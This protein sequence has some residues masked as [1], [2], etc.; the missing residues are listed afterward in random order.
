MKIDRAQPHDV[1]TILP[2]YLG[3]RRFYEVEEN[4]SQARDFILKRLQLNESVILRR[5]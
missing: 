1:D 2:L 5:V 4:A 3:Y